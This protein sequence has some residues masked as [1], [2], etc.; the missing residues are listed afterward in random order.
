MNKFLILKDARTQ[1]K[2]CVALDHII[3][4]KEEVCGENLTISLTGGGCIELISGFDALIESMRV[5]I[6]KKANV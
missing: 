5:L 6:N 4:I 2:T 3:S 1:L